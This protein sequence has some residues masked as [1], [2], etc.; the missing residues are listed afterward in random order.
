M[1]A[2]PYVDSIHIDADP[3]VVFDH[4]TDAGALANWMGD[5][6]RV[7]PRPGGEFSL[8]F[9]ERCVEGAYVVVERPRRVVISWGRR[10]SSSFPPA[11]SRLEV[12]LSPERG[13]TRVSITHSGLPEVEAQRH[14]L[15]WQHYLA[16]L[17]AVAAGADVP[18]HRTPAE[19]TE[20]VAD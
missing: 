14:A 4:F 18:S 9:G 12:V 13:G 17:S 8:F 16:R 15:G 2:D 6:A 19:L 7:D 11:T 1:T 10:G 5:K 3:D 20:G